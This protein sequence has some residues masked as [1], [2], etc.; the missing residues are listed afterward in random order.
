MSQFVSSIY[1]SNYL[2]LVHDLIIK[3]LNAFEERRVTQEPVIGTKAYEDIKIIMR[4]L[5][6]IVNQLCKVGKELKSYLRLNLSKLNQYQKL[7]KL[8]W[9]CQTCDILYRTHIA[10]LQRILLF[11]L[12]RLLPLE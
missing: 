10:G 1:Y 5:I 8:H 2:S 6:D 11:E 12:L 4:W 9:K 3:D 7:E